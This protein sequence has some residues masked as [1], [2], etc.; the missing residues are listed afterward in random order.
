[1]AKRLCY[2][3]VNTAYYNGNIIIKV[4]IAN[5][6]KKRLTAFNNGIKW[7]FASRSKYEYIP[8][9]IEYF[10]VM[11]E[12]RKSARSMEKAFYLKN[13]N[14]RNLLFGNEV[15]NFYPDKAID[16]IKSILRKRQK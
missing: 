13:K 6:I 8:K 12:S 16:D 9:F 14:N 4:G 2:L 10:N 11:L 5:N 15:Y 3:Y 1:M 7:R